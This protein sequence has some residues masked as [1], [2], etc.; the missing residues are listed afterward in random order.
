MKRIL[1]MA[2]VFCSPLLASSQNIA[3]LWKGT[4]YNDSTQQTLP[5]EIYITKENGKLS[6]YSHTWFAVN[7]KKYYGIKKVKIRV[8]KDGKVVVQ[9]DVLLVNDYPEIDKNVYQLNVLTITTVN[10]QT[11]LDGPFVTNRT[12]QYSELT[13]HI[14]LKKT[15]ITDQSALMDFLQRNNPENTIAATK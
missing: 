5:Y 8:A 15:A 12:K 14:N 10:E 1:F 6:G 4:I 2:A 11:V 7:D 9:D 3:G 13:G